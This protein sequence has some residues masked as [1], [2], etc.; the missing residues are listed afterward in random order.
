[1]S[2]LSQYID[3]PPDLPGV[4]LTE[5]ELSQWLH[6]ENC[7]ERRTKILDALKLELALEVSDWKRVEARYNAKD[8]LRLQKIRQGDPGHEVPDLTLELADEEEYMTTTFGYIDQLN[9]TIE[10]MTLTIPDLTST[11]ASA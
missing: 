11:P 2:E 5:A 6:L 7:A 8:E 9:T 3:L 1:M 4:V 10:A